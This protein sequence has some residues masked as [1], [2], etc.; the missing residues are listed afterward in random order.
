MKIAVATM[1]GGLDDMVSPVFGRCQT[2][3]IVEVEGNQI[4]GASVVPNQYASAMGGAGIQAGGFIASQGVK[5]AIGGNFG[6]NVAAVLSQSG[7]EMVAASGMKVR[8]AVQKYLNKE[9]L[10]ISQATA[11]A[12]RGM[13][14]GMGMGRGMGRGRGRG[15]GRGMGGGMMQ[16]WSMQQPMAWTGPSVQ[17]SQVSKEQQIQLLE[18]Q[19]RELEN[20]LE[21]IRNRLKELKK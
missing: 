17:P 4:R 19:A 14:G 16:Q 9:L 21:Q 7:I 6:P 20:Q 15:M 2:F 8:D 11:P 3:T 10:P 13:G 12:F 1:R 5:A 18:S